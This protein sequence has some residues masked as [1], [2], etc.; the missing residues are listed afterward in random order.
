MQFKNAPCVL[1]NSCQTKSIR[2]ITP[3]QYA[4]LSH[5][6][7]FQQSFWL[8]SFIFQRNPWALKCKVVSWHSQINPRSVIHRCKKTDTEN[9][10]AAG[11][12]LPKT[13]LHSDADLRDSWMKDLAN[14]DIKATSRELCCSSTRVVPSLHVLSLILKSHC[15]PSRHLVL[16]SKFGGYANH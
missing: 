15:R 2:K 13:G 8:K 14:V 10:S 11:E 16:N 6:T 5:S 9:L 4:N 7:T 12:K 1:I 3:I